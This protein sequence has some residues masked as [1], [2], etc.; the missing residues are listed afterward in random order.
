MC[1]LLA[2]VFQG[3]FLLWPLTVLMKQTRQAVCTFKQSILLRCL[4]AGLLNKSSYLTQVL[5]ATIFIT[6]IAMYLVTLIVL[7]NSK[8]DLH[9]QVEIILNT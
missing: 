8:S 1:W 6:I 7:P 2:P 9:V 5:G 3:F 4:W